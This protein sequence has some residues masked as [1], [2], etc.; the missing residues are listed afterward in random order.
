MKINVEAKLWMMLAELSLDR[1]NK[2]HTALIRMTPEKKLRLKAKE[3]KALNTILDFIFN[4]SSKA[5]F[6]GNGFRPNIIVSIESTR[7]TASNNSNVLSFTSSD[8]EPYFDDMYRYKIDFSDY[9][10]EDE[11]NPN[12]VLSELGEKFKKLVKHLR[13][14]ERITPVVKLSERN[15]SEND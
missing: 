3:E 9:V 7:I 10:K 1:V 6:R 8:V 5:T 14:D 15:S 11:N 12:S 2:A 4:N 13:Y